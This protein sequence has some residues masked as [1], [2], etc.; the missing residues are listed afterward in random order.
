MCFYN[1]ITNKSFI[2]TQSTKDFKI[3]HLKS[4]I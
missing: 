3:K 1:F 4:T 2:N